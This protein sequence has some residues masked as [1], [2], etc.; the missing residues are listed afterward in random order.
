MENWLNSSFGGY[1]HSGQ[2]DPSGVKANDFTLRRRG[3]FGSVSRPGARAPQMFNIGAG[4]TPAPK[5]PTTI[6]GGGMERGQGF[7]GVRPLMQY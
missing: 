5:V 2:G 1:P 7:G 6:M 4:A 3:G